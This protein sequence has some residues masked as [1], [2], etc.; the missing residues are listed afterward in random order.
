MGG[1][2]ETKVRGCMAVELLPWIRRG[3]YSV[4]KD[5]VQR[6]TSLLLEETSVI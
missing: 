1:R 6:D 3:I 5:K 2:R 4:F